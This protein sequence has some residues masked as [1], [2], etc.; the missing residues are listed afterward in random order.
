MERLTLR[1]SEAAP[2]VGERGLRALDLFCG[3]GGVTKGLQRAGFHVTGID[4][5]PQPQYCGDLFIQA[6]ALKPPVRLV[7]F[8]FIWASPPCQAYTTMQALNTR[9]P[10]RVHPELVEPV[11]AMLESCGVPYC[12][13]N[14]P[15]APMKHPIVLCGSM[16]GLRVR[17]HRLFEASFPMLTPPCQHAKQVEP[18]PV[19]GDGRPSRQEVRKARRQRSIAV[20][21][22]HPQQPGAG[23]VN[24][25]RTLAE[26][27]HAMGIDWMDWRP[28]TQAIPPAYSEF[29]ARAFLMADGAPERP[30]TV[31]RIPS[32]GEA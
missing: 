9:G 5:N 27:Q 28:L 25:A 18:V 22:D 30:G 7:D 10:K 15:G 6:D 26:G 21:G 31:R 24:R 19:W 17:R 16:F 11:R 2:S 14:V 29:I 1:G 8:D 12:I 3:G 23:T 4:L 32:S 13:E 20:Y